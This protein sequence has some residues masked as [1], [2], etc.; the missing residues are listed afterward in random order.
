MKKDK[1]IISILISVA[2]LLL[3][4]TT[5]MLQE[6]KGW[7]ETTPYHAWPFYDY[8]VRCEHTG[9][10]NASDDTFTATM[11]EGWYDMNPNPPAYVSGEWG[12]T[13][14]YGGG[15][16]HHLYTT[17]SP[18]Y[19]SYQYGS[20]AFVH[21]DYNTPSFG[22]GPY[23]NVPAYYQD[24]DKYLSSFNPSRQPSLQGGAQSYF[25]DPNNP[26]DRWFVSSWIN[27]SYMTA[28]YP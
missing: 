22:Y 17:D 9:T 6:V 25:K 16:T 4:L 13:R 14:G 28:R 20:Y 12:F 19:C 23:G 11:I 24:Y 8:C 2:F 7:G 5:L 26:N 1:T 15:G 21:Y 10:F 27:P 18:M 3:P